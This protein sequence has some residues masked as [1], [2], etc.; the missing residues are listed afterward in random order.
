M[1]SRTGLCAPDL[2]GKLTLLPG[3]VV[4]FGPEKATGKKM[5]K[6]KK[7]KKKVSNEKK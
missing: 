2:A 4:R 6:I 3:S 7:D 5:N 1:H